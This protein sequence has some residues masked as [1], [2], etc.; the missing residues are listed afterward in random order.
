M[1][2]QENTKI[3]KQGYADF[4]KGDIPAILAIFGEDIVFDIPG[5]SEVPMARQWRGLPEM[6]EFLATID[7]ELQFTEFTPREFIAQGDR[8]VAVGNYT[9]NVKRTGK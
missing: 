9:A 6:R 1:T 7:R 3:I 5:P 2:E 8:V 4:Q